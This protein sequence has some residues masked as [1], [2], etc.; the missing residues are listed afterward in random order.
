[1]SVTMKWKG[2]D[3]FTKALHRSVPQLNNQV[4]DAVAQ[5]A[6]EMTDIAKRLAPV[7]SGD[8]RESITWQWDNQRRIKYAQGLQMSKVSGLGYAA[9]ITVGNSKVRY[10]HLVEFGSSPHPQGGKFKGTYHPGTPAQPFFFPAYRMV[11]ARM[12]RR[13]SRAVNAAL[14]RSR[15]V[16]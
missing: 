11:R 2:V 3:Q 7:D 15:L 12:R 1:M 14:K 9:V 4:R 13:I 6:N 16:K 5:S 10:A 8:L